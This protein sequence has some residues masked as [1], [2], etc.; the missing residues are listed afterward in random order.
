MIQ[1]SVLFCTQRASLQVSEPASSYLPA[2][3]GKQGK[4]SSL[5]SPGP[6]PC[7][8]QGRNKTP[9]DYGKH[10]PM[11]T[12]DAYE[13][14]SC[15]PQVFSFIFSKCCCIPYLHPYLQ[16]FSPY[17]CPDDAEGIRKQ[18]SHCKSTTFTAPKL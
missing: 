4:D 10:L 8:E 6:C 1:Y 5:L 14:T 12:L 13:E 2:Q 11:H 15:F 9:M 16:H 3:S 7:T 18:K 17:P